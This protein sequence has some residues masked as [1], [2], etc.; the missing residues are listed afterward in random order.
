MKLEDM[1]IREL[2]PKPWAEGEKIPW[3]DADFSERMLKEHLSQVHD[4]ASRRQATIDLHVAWIAETCL[5]KKPARI[6]DLGC[7]P[8]FYSQRLAQ[9]GHSCVGIDFSPASIAHAK[10][11][12][13]QADLSIDYTCGDIRTADYGD[14]FDLAMMIFGEFNVFS[15]DDTQQLLGNIH[16]ALKPGGCILLEPQTYEAIQQDGHSPACWHT[17]DSGL[18]SPDSHLWLDEHFWHDDCHAAT[19]RYFIIDAT[20]G[21]IDKYASTTQAYTDD[22]FDGLLADA[23]FC[24]VQRFPSLTGTEEHQQVGLFV[25]MAKKE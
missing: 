19:T 24:D 2:P 3:D 1:I 15:K 7:G 5:Q 12:A 23:G 13:A 8:G 20:T 14:G 10:A 16:E 11:Q 22:D 6:L 4:M 18:F 17:H 9:Q 25:L 21:S